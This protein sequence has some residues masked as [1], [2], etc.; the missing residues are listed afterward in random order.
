MQPVTDS[1]KP[2]TDSLKPVSASLKE[3]IHYIIRSGQYGPYI[4]KKTKTKTDKPLFISV[5]KGLA[6]ESLTD[7]EIDAIFKAG[8]EQ[9]QRRKKTLPQNSNDSL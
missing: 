4:T 6:V 7:K 9:K 3:T 5:P 2:V 1:L 8:V